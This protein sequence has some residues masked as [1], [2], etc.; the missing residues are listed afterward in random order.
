MLILFCFYFEKSAVS[1]CLGNLRCYSEHYAVES[2]M[3]LLWG[4]PQNFLWDQKVRYQW[5]CLCQGTC[6]AMLCDQGEVCER[7][8][9]IFTNHLKS[10][11]LEQPPCFSWCLEY[12]AYREIVRDL[13][14]PG[15]EVRRWRC[16]VAFLFLIRCFVAESSALLRC[17]EEGWG[18]VV[19]YRNG[20]ILTGRK[21]K[22]ITI[23]MVKLWPEVCGG[24]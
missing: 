12:M 17:T 19:T 2:F 18:A 21:G 15:L 13:G 22:K 11:N 8:F 7:L 10:F 5:S 20:E 9:R 6:E 1:E 16:I 24:C 23:G 14:L 4:C 3:L